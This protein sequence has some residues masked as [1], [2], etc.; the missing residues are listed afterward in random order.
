MA[1]IRL[2]K[3]G[4]ALAARKNSKGGVTVFRKDVFKVYTVKTTGEKV[5]VNESDIFL[6]KSEYVRR[7]V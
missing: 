3:R 2:T 1:Q 7:A 4:Q 5:L 6:E